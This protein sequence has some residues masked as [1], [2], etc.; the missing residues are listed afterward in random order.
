MVKT[1]LGGLKKGFFNVKNQLLT[2]DCTAILDSKPTN[3][4]TDM[5]TIILVVLAF[6]NLFFLN[7]SNKE[8]II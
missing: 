2:D 3:T 7:V 1:Q 5:A 4:Q 8:I 6:F